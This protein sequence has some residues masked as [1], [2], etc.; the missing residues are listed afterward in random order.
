M[1]KAGNFTEG[2][3]WQIYVVFVC[4]RIS[5]AVSRNSSGFRGSC[6]FAV[7]FLYQKISISVKL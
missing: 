1:Y 4:V 6:I 2:L 3:Q 7:G 5:F